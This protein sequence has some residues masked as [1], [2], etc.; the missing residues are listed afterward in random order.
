M[1]DNSKPKFMRTSLFTFII[2]LFLGGIFA[3]NLAAQDQKI[4]TLP[5]PKT[6]GGVPLMKALKNRQTSRE[7]NDRKLSD[8]VMSNLLWAAWGVNRDDA[9]KRTAPS[10][11]NKQ[12][13]DIYIS[14][15]EGVFIYDAFKNNLLQISNED[16][17]DKTGLQ[18]FVK[19][20]PVNLVFVA[21]FSKMGTSADPDKEKYAYADAAFISENVYLFCASE[22]LSTGV[23]ANI[24]KEKCAKALKLKPEQHVI[25][26]QAVGYP[27]EKTK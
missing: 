25:L 5:A 7:F 13:I 22:K 12:E 14:T 11:M 1:T 21:D 19:T 2:V 17:R 6:D 8:Q 26:G 27:K 24:D 15:A 23:R 16:V 18:D 10:A 9:K 4:I 3:L 20:A